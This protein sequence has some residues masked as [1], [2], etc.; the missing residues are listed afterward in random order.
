MKRKRLRRVTATTEFY[1]LIRENV[2]LGLCRP[3]NEK[4][5]ESTRLAWERARLN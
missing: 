1:R 2:V 4:Q 3:V 5:E